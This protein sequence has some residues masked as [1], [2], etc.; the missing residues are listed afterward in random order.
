MKPVIGITM[1]DPSGIGSEIAVKALKHEDIYE[2]CLPVVIG[3][4]EALRQANEFSKTGLELRKISLPREA[5]GKYGALDLIDLGFLAPG[6]FEYK[7][8]QRL[9]GEASF[10]YV[11][12]SIDLA[13]NG[14]LHAVVTGPINKEAIN[15]AGHH[16]SG[17]TEIFGDYT[18]TKDFA[19]LLSGGN[20]KVIHVTTHCS[21]RD[22]CDRIKRERVLSVIKLA[23]E[24]LSLMDCKNPRIG[25]AGLN[26]H[27][28]ENG[29]FGW[30]EEREISPA[31]DD[32]KALGINAEGPVPPDTVFVKCQAG[33][34]DVVVAMYHD[35][36][37]IPL[38]LAGFKLDIATNRYSSMSG[39]NSTIGLPVIRTSVDHGTAFGK[40]G[41]GRANEESL[42]DAIDVAV[43]MAKN[44]FGL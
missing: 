16:Y 32:A 27:S 29:L 31:I 21:M 43:V 11:I 10:Q 44:K 22:A 12:K 19:M 42:V 20:I 14:E 33:Q 13:M 23:H 7:K 30:E 35:Q 15:M 36:G 6:S 26:A 28:S 9:C 2:K 3:D 1:G 39:V 38:K 24:G 17:H 5:A 8:V 34:Y 25:V 18:K 40:A 37:H 41:E 4:Y